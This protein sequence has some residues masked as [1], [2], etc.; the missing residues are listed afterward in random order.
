MYGKSNYNQGRYGGYGDYG[1]YGDYGGQGGYRDQYGRNQ[2][3]MTA[4]KREQ[5][6]KAERKQVLV[7]DLTARLYA[8]IERAVI[9]L[10]GKIQP[11]F[12]EFAMNKDLA[13]RETFQNIELTVTGILAMLGEKV[14][15]GLFPSAIVASV[16]QPEFSLVPHITNIQKFVDMLPQHKEIKAHKTILKQVLGGLVKGELCEIPADLSH[17]IVSA[18]DREAIASDFITNNQ[19]DMMRINQEAQAQARYTDE[20]LDKMERPTC[21]KRIPGKPIRAKSLYPTRKNK[22]PY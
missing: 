14:S 6:S 20:Q 5:L 2:Q 3:Q 18:K 12:A 7:N 10:G 8:D 1:R 9:L 19:T 16:P 13:L 4:G 11:K 17:A 15:T 22:V 21:I